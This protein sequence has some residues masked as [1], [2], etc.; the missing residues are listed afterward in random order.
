MAGSN[1]ISQ[2]AQGEYTLCLRGALQMAFICAAVLP[3]RQ[4]A[5]GV[6]L[7]AR[8]GKADP[9]LP[10]DEFQRVT[11]A[12]LCASLCVHRKLLTT[13]S[14]LFHRLSAPSLGVWLISRGSREL[15]GWR[16]LVVLF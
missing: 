12:G 4:V 15:L 14:L 3:M 13:H 10:A 6:M 7:G 16:P 1:R 9:C 5:L 2:S 8:E 11:A